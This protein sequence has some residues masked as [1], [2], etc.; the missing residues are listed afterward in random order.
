MKI[1]GVLFAAF[2][3]LAACAATGQVPWINVPV[4]N[5][6]AGQYAC[7]TRPTYD[8]SIAV[9]TCNQQ[10]VA[11]YPPPAQA[12]LYAHEHGHVYQ[13]VYNPQMLMSPYVEY[14]ADCYAAT[15]MAINDPASL[16]A[17]I[18]WFQQVLGPYGGDAIHGNGFQMAARAFQCAQ[19]V[20]PNFVVQDY[21]EA[22]PIHRRPHGSLANAF[23]GDQSDSSSTKTYPR[24][25]GMSKREDNAFPRMK[26]DVQPTVCTAVE[27]LADSAHTS[28]WEASD[29]T[30]AISPNISSALG[31]KCSVTGTLRRQVGCEREL[32]KANKPDWNASLSACLSAKEWSKRCEDAECSSQLYE[33]PGDGNDHLTIRLRTLG[34]KQLL[35]FIAPTVAPHAHDSGAYVSVK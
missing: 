14:D 32:N 10:V 25:K 21:P 2:L 3:V 1:R 6:N 27:Y 29:Q 35:E 28:F 22:V 26:T 9:I 31:G 33:H 30:G 20:R 13:I 7:V 17:A 19:A 23:M 11:M 5:G 16:A 34:S 15:Y 8:Q 12:F 4:V 24:P 18:R